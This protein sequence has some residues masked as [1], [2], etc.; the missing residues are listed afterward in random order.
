MGIFDE[1]GIYGMGEI[2]EVILA[3][4]VSGDPILL[5]GRHGSAKTLLARRIARA[6]GLKFIAYDAS[7][8]LFDDVIGFPNP[9]LLGEGKLD[10]IPTPISIWDK[11]F[12][13][14][15]EISRANPSMQN[16][17]LEVIRSRQ[18][19]G[20]KIPNLKYVFAA[21]NPVDGYLG[22]VELDPALIG[23]FALIIPVPDVDR[24]SN[25]DINAVITNTSED[26]A[27]AIGIDNSPTFS[28][29]IS[30]LVD[31]ARK[32][33]PE[34]VT[35]YDK[36]VTDY[37]SKILF[38]FAAEK[39]KLDGRRLG[40]IRRN[41]LTYLAIKQFNG[42]GPGIKSKLF[43]CLFLSLKYSLPFAASGEKPREDV[44]QMVH[45][46][47]VKALKE[48]KDVSTKISLLVEDNPVALV[49]NYQRYYRHI[50]RIQH[51]S[52]V[53]QIAK[54]WQEANKAKEVA[55]VYLAT[56]NLLKFY[57]K[58]N[59]KCPA[60]V[61]RRT[62]NLYI[63][64]TRL[65]PQTR[66]ADAY[67]NLF[68][69]RENKILSREIS[70]NDRINNIAIRLSANLHSNHGLGFMT[71]DLVN[72]DFFELLKAKLRNMEEEK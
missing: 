17:W 61:L 30:R 45:L 34:I 60:D 54:K 48:N 59:G 52:I 19:M 32:T 29:K 33:F 14:I 55:E 28:Q 27:V 1:L 41:C 65:L 46:M 3:G 68:K 15:D 35:R 24:M 50:P 66:T 40:M 9:H 64:M 25:D 70:L 11:E 62:A 6:L 67:E 31:Q 4:L 5:V 26:D 49:E 37:T 51:S 72:S 18:I 38:F 39:V 42:D 12:I 20:R 2:E 57:E 43:D 69:D 71:N 7:K 56:K 44:L 10:Y 23:R 36:L 58:A 63:E 22:T 16:K 8:A 53:G 21:M 47:A 13:L